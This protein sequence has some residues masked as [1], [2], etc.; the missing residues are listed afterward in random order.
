M[1]SSLKG[2]LGSREEK[3]F[4][5]EVRRG[6][7]D[8]REDRKNAVVRSLKILRS[9][10][11]VCTSHTSQCRVAVSSSAPLVSRIHNLIKTTFYSSKI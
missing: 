3:D 10:S 7:K 1:S 6:K 2:G 9:D 4:L 8:D 5:T 11:E